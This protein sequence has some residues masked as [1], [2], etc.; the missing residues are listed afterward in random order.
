MVEQIIPQIGQSKKK[1]GVKY[2]IN[3]NGSNQLYH[4]MKLNTSMFVLEIEFDPQC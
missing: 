1:S 3:T 4:A 2:D